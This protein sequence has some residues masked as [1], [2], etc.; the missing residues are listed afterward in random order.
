MNVSSP[1]TTGSATNISS[2]P[3]AAQK[4]IELSSIHSTSLVDVVS[5][6]LK[7]KA[8]KEPTI[9]IKSCK[10]KTPLLL[11]ISCDEGDEDGLAD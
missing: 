7:K 6:S 5:V 2:T 10:R 9:C 3:P 4:D 11:E 8:V 1:K